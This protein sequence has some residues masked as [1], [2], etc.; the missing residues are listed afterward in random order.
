MRESL[1]RFSGVPVRVFLLCCALALPAF[2]AYSASAQSDTGRGT[3]LLLEIASYGDDI[4]GASAFYASL[5]A[6]DQAILNWGWENMTVSDESPPAPDAALTM[7]T[8]SSGCTEAWAEQGFYSLG[9]EQFRFSSGTGWCWSGATITSVW[10][11]GMRPGPSF[12]GWQYIGVWGGGVENW[13]TTAYKFA[14]AQYKL[15]YQWCIQERHPWIASYGE[16]DYAF[17]WNSGGV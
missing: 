14:Q 6:D 13:G 17:W 12:L 7:A 15:C 10:T 1:P 11:L 5:S 2:H 4:E 3:A 16:A 8:L 9:V